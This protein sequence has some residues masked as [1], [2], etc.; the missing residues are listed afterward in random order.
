MGFEL[1]C[2]WAYELACGYILVTPLIIKK[3]HTDIPWREMADMRNVLI[4]SYYGVSLEQT[5]NVIQ[6]DL[7]PLKKQI[8]AILKDIE[9]TKK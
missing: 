4:H 2:G 7:P 5:W 8:K 6:K 9:S 3:K 1:V